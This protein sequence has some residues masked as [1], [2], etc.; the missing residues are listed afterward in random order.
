[1][2]LRRSVIMFRSQSLN[3]ELRK[4][5]TRL[6]SVS[7]ALP[8]NN[9]AP[10]L[11]SENAPLSLKGNVR[12]ILRRSVAILMAKRNV[13]MSLER[14]VGMNQGRSAGTNL[15][16]TANRFLRRSAGMNLDRNVTLSRF[17]ILT[18]KIMKSAPLS[19]NLYAVL[20]Q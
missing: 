4:S 3:T 9:P 13:G 10:P 12:L 1:M 16:L 17:P 6:L 2:L 15:R 18:M 20:F 5:V 7:V 11:Q 14:S 8:M 19:T